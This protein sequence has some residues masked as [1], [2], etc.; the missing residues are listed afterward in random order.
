MP[1]RLLVAKLK[2][3]KPVLQRLSE[4]IPWESFAYCMKK[5]YVQ[6]RK[7]SADQLRIPANSLQM[8]MLQQLFKLTIGVAFCLRLMKYSSR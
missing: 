8:L 2:N 7:S 6:E 3:R 4:S 5:D 1:A